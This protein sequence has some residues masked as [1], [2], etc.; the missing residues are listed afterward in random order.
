M[1]KAVVQTT[2]LDAR[3]TRAKARRGTRKKALLHR[4]FS[5]VPANVTV[6]IPMKL[7]KLGGRKRILSPDGRATPPVPVSATENAVIRALARAHRWQQLLET[8]AYASV[9]DLARAEKISE[10]YL[11]R[12]L[13]LTLLAPKIIEAL[14]IEKPDGL[15][16]ETLLKPIPVEWWKQEDL[17][18]PTACQPGC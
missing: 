14:L 9:T 6:H 12:V 3:E 17:V 16:A 11:G 13:R 4:R 2:S 10:T 7:H 8:Q 1:R 18:D 15:F 5:N